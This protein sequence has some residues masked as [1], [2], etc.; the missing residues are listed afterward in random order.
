M[1]TSDKTVAKAEKVLSSPAAS[2]SAKKA[3][4]AFLSAK[5]G[6]SEKFRAAFD[7]ASHTTGSRKRA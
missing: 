2:S 7:E 3:A 6:Q 5:A 1:I 4:A